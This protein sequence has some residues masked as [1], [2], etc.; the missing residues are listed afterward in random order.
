MTKEPRAR[1]SVQPKIIALARD[2][3]TVQQI[4]GR[5]TTSPNH[6]RRTLEKAGIV[7]SAQNV[8]TKKLRRPNFLDSEAHLQIAA[9]AAALGIEPHTIVA[10]LLDV[11]VQVGDLDIH[12][13]LVGVKA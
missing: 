10:H 5:L 1:G 13:P 8:P 6:V 9:R 3:M 4:A 12:F 2:G 11:A 7:T